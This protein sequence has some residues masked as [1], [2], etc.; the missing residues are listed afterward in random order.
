MGA[1]NGREVLSRFRNHPSEIW[2]RG[3]DI[4]IT[5]TLLNPRPNR[6]AG[7]PAWDPLDAAR[8]LYPKMYP[9]MLESIQQL[10]ASG[11]LSFEERIGQQ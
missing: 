10:G 5:H 4:S 11:L 9:R 8:N 7:T 1:R 2:H 6:L 3:E